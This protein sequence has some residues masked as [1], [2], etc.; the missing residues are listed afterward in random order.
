MTDK[1]TIRFV[2]V[3]LGLITLLLI[4]GAIGMTCFDKNVPEALWTLAGTGVGAFTSLL[5]S[6]RSIETAPPTVVSSRQP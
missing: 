6:T 1:T 4:G 3:F 2:V 5:V